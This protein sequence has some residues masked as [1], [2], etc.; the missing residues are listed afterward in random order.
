MYEF[1]L[2]Q[3][4][5][6]SK[7]D[8]A[9]DWTVGVNGTHPVTISFPLTVGCFAIGTEGASAGWRYM[10]NNNTEGFK[11]IF[12]A[13]RTRDATTDYFS[14]DTV[15][16]N[17]AD[18]LSRYQTK[19]FT[20]ASELAAISGFGGE[21]TNWRTSTLW[22]FIWNSQSQSFTTLANVQAD[23]ITE[24]TADQN[25]MLPGS[26]VKY[27]FVYV[28][29]NPPVLLDSTP[30]TVTIVPVSAISLNS[31]NQNVTKDD[32]AQFTISAVDNSGGIGVKSIT[33]D[34][35]TYNTSS[36]SH[37]VTGGGLHTITASAEDY[38]G[39]ITP[40]VTYSVFIDQTPPSV[41]IQSQNPI[42]VS[43]RNYHGSSSVDIQI[44]TSDS[45]SGLDDGDLIINGTSSVFTIVPAQTS[46]TTTVGS[47]Q[48]VV[49]G[50]NTVEYVSKDVAGNQSTANVIFYVDTTSPDGYIV[51]S[52]QN[53]IRLNGSTYYT[54]LTNV[55]VDLHFGDSGSYPSGVS[56]G[57]IKVNDSSIP[58]VS[59]FT[60]GVDLSSE[61]SPKTS[62]NVTGLSVGQNNTLSFFVMD[63][64]ENISTGDTI[65]VTVEQINPSGSIQISSLETPKIT[66]STTN[67]IND[68]TVELNLTHSDSESDLF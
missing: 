44:D 30:P 24:I 54:H 9:N 17:D 64:A 28:G 57:L 8:G 60:S 38:G 46:Y 16:L 41:A 36:R 59:D 23:G 40:N 19:T 14:P 18:F 34:G 61:T 42:A 33:I 47:A 27:T 32:P 35:T 2:G 31:S 50:L 29:S 26:S 39:N 67:Y 22:A 62:Y 49:E 15:L 63:F 20:S 53:K 10:V 58:S 11:R 4:T 68:G 3:Q 45:G 25:T 66:K 37:S 13:A 7:S 65:S 55:D 6:G 56:K 5:S 51:F 12:R 48:G 1:R 43:L 21:V 52:P